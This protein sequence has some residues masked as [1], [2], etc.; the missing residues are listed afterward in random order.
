MRLVCVI[1]S[2]TSLVNGLVTVDLENNVLQDTFFTTTSRYYKIY[3][4]PECIL[5]RIC[6]I[7]PSARMEIW[8]ILSDHRYFSPLVR[9]IFGIFYNHLFF[10]SSFNP[11][12]HLTALEQELIKTQVRNSKPFWNNNFCLFFYLV[13]RNVWSHLLISRLP[14]FLITGGIRIHNCIESK[15]W[16]IAIAIIFFVL[17]GI[18]FGTLSALAGTRKRQSKNENVNENFDIKIIKK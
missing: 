15:W 13:F 12:S 1:T 3:A 9:W 18:V 11:N 16:L 7:Y 5:L 8:F 14:T 10:S 17:S 2:F 4:K 6:R